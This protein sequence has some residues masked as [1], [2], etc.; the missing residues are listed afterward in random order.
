MQ[1]AT[2]S[3]SCSLHPTATPARLLSDAA[4]A[5]GICCVGTCWVPACACACAHICVAS[6]PVACAAAAAAVRC[7]VTSPTAATRGLSRVLWSAV[8]HPPSFGEGG[9]RGWVGLGGAAAHAAPDQV[10]TVWSSSCMNSNCHHVANVRHV[11][12]DTTG[13]LFIVSEVSKPESVPY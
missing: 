1:V 7:C 10:T 5:P 6:I 13:L 2:Q 12:L 4:A 9:A 8:L 11:S 3:S